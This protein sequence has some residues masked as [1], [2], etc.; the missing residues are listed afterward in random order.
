[1]RQ[2][3]GMVETRSLVAALQAA[4]TMVK[5]ADVHIVDLNFVGS[6]LIAA[7]V[8]GEVAAV[9]AAVENA[10]ETAKGLGEI[11]SSNVIPRPHEEVD[12]MLDVLL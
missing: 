1:M 7:I 5:S 12:K 6:G 9:Q 4:D 3:I 8:S 2:A 11:I 10:T